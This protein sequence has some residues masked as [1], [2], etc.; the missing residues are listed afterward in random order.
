MARSGRVV[1]LLAGAILLAG[2]QWVG[3]GRRIELWEDAR[4]DLEAQVRRARADGHRRQAAA[5][6]TGAADGSKVTPTVGAAAQH[7]VTEGDRHS[8]LLGNKGKALL[9]FWD[10]VRATDKGTRFRRGRLGGGLGTFPGGQSTGGQSEGEGGRS[11]HTEFAQPLTA[12]QQIMASEMRRQVWTALAPQGADSEGG[13]KD[14]E[15]SEEAEDCVARALKLNRDSS[16]DMQA[17]KMAAREWRALRRPASEGI[18]PADHAPSLE[19]VVRFND[20]QEDLAPAHARM[21]GLQKKLDQIV[22]KRNFDTEHLTQAR[23]QARDPACH[24]PLS[25]LSAPLLC[26]ARRRGF[27]CRRTPCAYYCCPLSVLSGGNWHIGRLTQW[28]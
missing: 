22:N 4:E 25:N 28:F 14:A 1:L 10:G 15:T 6:A 8:P 3:R 2:R 23:N 17:M 26:P 7:E 24:A 19:D 18:G 5:D 11:W 27:A 21:K 20:K 16:V 9:D 12:N 13:C